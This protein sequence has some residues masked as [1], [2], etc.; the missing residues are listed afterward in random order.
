MDFLFEMIKNHTDLGVVSDFVK[1]FD[2]IFTVLLIVAGA[3]LVLYCVKW[4]IFK[5]YCK[6]TNET[7]QETVTKVIYELDELADH[8]SNKEKKKKAIESVRSLFIW[9]AIPIP[10]VIIGVIIDLEVAAI[11]KLQ[12]ES[13][14]E[15][16]P[17][18]HP[19]EEDE[20]SDSEEVNNES[21]DKK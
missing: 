19:D 1:L 2:M 7:I 6:T 3:L 4:L 13:L 18:L 9:R 5:I 21:L 10:P 17:Y 8:M 11:R 15:K 20:E 12:K 14:E 16:D